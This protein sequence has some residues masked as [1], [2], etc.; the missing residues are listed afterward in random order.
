MLPRFFARVTR[1]AFGDLTL[2]DAR[3]EDYI[4]DLLTRFAR[5]EALA[6]IDALPGRRLPTVVD[7]LLEIQRVW[8][9]EG[10]R[11]D[12][13]KERA[14]RRHIGDYTLFMTGVFR[15]RV[16]RLASTNYYVSQGQRAYRF[17]SEHGRATSRAQARE[18][19]P[20]FAR[21][22][23]RFEHYAWALDYAR[24]VH[25]YDAPAHPFFKLGWQ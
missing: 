4:T 20:L 8:E 23:E 22:A 19:A 16:Q 21:L 7:A 15:E 10:P 12:P 9:W 25:F 14:V 18:S 2:D 17:V 6:A 1:S 13:G 11:F 3:A 5:T 24:R